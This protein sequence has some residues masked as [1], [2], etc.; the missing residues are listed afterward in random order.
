MLNSFMISDSF[1]LI[2]VDADTFQIGFSWLMTPCFCSVLTCCSL[3]I[4]GGGD[5]LFWSLCYLV[6]CTYWVPW[7]VRMHASL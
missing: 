6:L 5:T 7:I 1:F 2:L 4:E 3:Y